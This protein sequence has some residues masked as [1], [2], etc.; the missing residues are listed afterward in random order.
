MKESE[1]R[2]TKCAEWLPS[3][4]GSPPSR[5]QSGCLPD[6]HAEAHLPGA[7][8]MPLRTQHERGLLFAAASSRTDMSPSF[9]LRSALPKGHILPRP[10]ACHVHGAASVPPTSPL[11]LLPNSH[12]CCDPAA[13]IGMDVAAEVCNSG[14]LGPV[15][16]DTTGS[17]VET[18]IE[19]DIPLQTLCERL[20]RFMSLGVTITLAGCRPV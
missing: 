11:G 12:A 16:T 8:V 7:A 4:R 9:A 6:R 13:D 2:G 18:S 5:A 17:L 10:C 15:D 1:S 3:L 14:S 19:T 20:N